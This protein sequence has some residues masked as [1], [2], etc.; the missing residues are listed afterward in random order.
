MKRKQV[1]IFALL[2]ALPLAFGCRQQAPEPASQTQSF[3][4]S[5]VRLLDGPFAHAAEKNAAYV[6][7]HDPDRLLAPFLAEAGLEPKAERYGNW[8]N[9]G[10][11]G[12]TAGHY[13]TSL[14]LMTASMDHQEAAER[15][16][17]MLDELQRCQEADPDGYVGGIPGGKAMWEDIAAGKIDAGLFSLNGKWVPLYN[18]HKLFA[19]LYDSWQYTGSQQ[20]LD[21]LIKLSDYF[22]NISADLSNEQIQQMLVSEHGGMNDVFA[23]VYKA[24]GNE[25]YL[26]LAERFSH[27]LVL[28]PLLRHEDKLTGMHAN[29]QIPKVIGFMQIARLKG[30]SAWHDA[31]RY[32]WETVVQN[33]SIAIGGNSTHEHFHPSDDFSS[34]IET[35]EGPETCNTY[36]MM[37]LSKQ[38]YEASNDLRYIDFYERAMY[39]H[40]LASQ[41][42]EHGGLVYFTPVRPQHYRV[43][44]NPEET[45]WCCVGSGIENHAKYGELVFSHDNENLYVNLFMPAQLTWAEKGLK[46][47]QETHFPEEDKTRLRIETEQ[48]QSMTIFVRHPGWNDKVPIEVTVNGKKVR[49]HSKAGEY[50]ALQRE[51]QNNDVIELSFHTYTYAEQ[52]PD[53]SSYVALLHGPVVLAAPSGQEDL[54]GLIADDSRMG[55]IA[56]GKLIS[57]EDA[58]VLLT[59]QNNWINQIKAVKDRPLHFQLTN[60]VHPAEAEA[61]ELKPFY[62]VH[63][64]RYIVY[65]QTT[66]SE[67]LQE[68]KEL[69]KAKEEAAMAL[70]AQTIDHIDTGQQQPESDHNFKSEGSEAGVHMDRHWR[71]ATGWFSYELNDPDQEAKALRVTYFGGDTNRNFDILV[72]GQVLSTVKLDGSKGNVFFDVDYPLSSE[73]ISANNKGKMQ[74]TFKAAP[75]SIAG[76]VYF[77]RL[78]R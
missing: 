36:N 58:P 43:Y 7:A 20:A 47:T 55:H 49:A 56:H 12:H 64:S 65:W 48:T 39:N 29:T 26:K 61:L 51:W 45:F 13:L 54:Q 63:D 40:I 19:G 4:L 35:R 22:V 41:H 46:L 38:L 3:P 76:G 32:F 78:L 52:L 24:T 1:F 23:L 9:T 72:N 10:L 70:E 73:L 37:K 53:G 69:L 60:L 74:L 17:Y 27:Q 59:D 67:A 21:I 31:S 71:H 28:Q 8:E 14:A 15:L 18:I 25:K 42:P 77:V 30:D 62:Q 57:R 50:L 75:N 66:T 5:A 6:M 44:S 2:L 33:R 11:D 34:M 68:E 16:Q